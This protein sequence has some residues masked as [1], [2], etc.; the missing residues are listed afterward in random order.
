[1]L[2]SWDSPQA[3]VDGV[4]SKLSNKDLIFGFGHRVYM[5]KGDPR[6][7]VAKQISKVLSQ[8]GLPGANPALFAIS[9]AA[10][11][12]MEQEKGIKANLDFYTA[13]LYDQLGIPVGLFTPIFVFS[14][15]LGWAAHI[16][17]QRMNNRLIRPSASYIGKTQQELPSSV[18]FPTSFANCGDNS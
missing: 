2:K 8:S 14:R 4:K 9:E 12:T 11:S 16:H 15:T 1:M 17:E 7:P 10:E 18:V 13:S 5:K 3:A 6:N